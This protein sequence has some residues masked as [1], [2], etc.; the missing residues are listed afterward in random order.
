MLCTKCGTESTTGRKF[1]AACG[2][3]LSSRCPKC[4]AE[5]A[6]S[7]A[8]CEDCGAAIAGNAASSSPQV[9]LTTPEIRVTLGQPDVSTTLDGERKTVTAV[10]ADIRGSTEL[11]EDLDPEEARAIIDPALKLMIEAVQR[12]DG[13][14]VQSTGDGI[15]ALFGA[16][17]AHEDH[18]QRALYAALRMQE[19]L[20]RY[21]ERI[22]RD[23]R[24]PLQARVG[25]NT[26]EVVVR[27]LQTGAA[28]TEYTPI[29]HTTNLA[30]RIQALAPIG[31]IAVSEATRKLCEGYFVL[32][33]LGPTQIKGLSEP[34]NVSEVTGLGALRTHFQVSAHRGLTKFVGREREM[35]ALKRALEQ[36][37]AGRGQIAAAI[38]EPGVGKSRLFFEFKAVS[39]SGC[40]VLE[41]FSVSHGKASAY[42]PVLDFLY[43]YF[44]IKS[45]DDERKRREKVNG[46]IVTLDR[47]LEDALPY[48]FALLGI[49]EGE[50]PLAQMDGQIKKRR[51][52]EAIK[53]IL[54][55][56]SLNQPLIVI[57]EDLHWIDEQTQEFLNLLADSIGTAKIL[58]LVNYRPEYSHQWGS[59][60]YYTQLRLDPLGNESADEML[61]ALLGDDAAL[62]PLKRVIIEKTEGTPFFMEE[63][64]QVL[65]DEGALVRNGVVKLT[66]P[67]GE[68]KIPPTVQ[69]ILASRID[70]LLPD[71]KDLL[72]TLAVIG[73][74]FTLLLIRTV[75]TKPDNELSRLLNDLQLGEFIYEQPTVGDAEYIFKHALTQEVA[76]NSVLMER[77]KQ[78][79]ERIGAAL[80]TLYASS[81]DDHL[82]ELAHHY[83]RGNNPAKAVD[84]LGRAAR[85]AASRSAFGEAL[86]HARAGIALIPSMPASA[87]HGKRE[88][89][90]LP[91]LVRAATA[92]DGYGSPQTEQGYRRMLELARESGDDADLSTALEGSRVDH[93]TS[94]RHREAVEMARQLM[95]VAE[96][97]KKPGALADA[98]HARGFTLF[99]T[100]RYADS[101]SDLDRAITL[102]PDGAGRISLNVA[103]PLVESLGYAALGTWTLGFPD[104]AVNRIESAVKRSRDLRQPLLLSFALFFQTWIRLWRGEVLAAQRSCE[105]LEMLA[106]ESGFAPWLALNRINQGGIASMNGEHEQ[107]IALIRSGIANWTPLALTYHSSILARSCMQ[108]GRY[109]EA[110]DAVGVGREHVAR[111]GELHAE[112]EIERMAG[113]TL[114]RMG[115]ANIDEAGQC[116][117][118]AVA[119]AKGQG[120]KS[121]ELRATTS[122][123]RLLDKQNR[124][125]DAR[126]IVAEIYAWFT[127]GFDTADLRDAKALLDKLNG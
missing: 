68:L 12:Y 23:G 110:M 35:E 11:M 55:R 15:F 83:H 90:L 103:D 79:H 73:R 37:K 30:S 61:T 89:D 119:I 20:K 65:F 24:L 109:E 98:H 53:R 72:Q 7:S 26:G 70:R 9:A 32:R 66:K 29:G 56:E 85:Q 27:T 101:L 51:T 50:D 104:R 113:E 74:E 41:T 125:D 5:N 3:R 42:L 8:F 64:V 107:G 82:A 91:T 97:R 84:Y 94:G 57:F 22:R 77:R 62:A 54:L 39:Q 58:L 127:E 6:P 10:F 112:S 38:A 114:L 87:V 18:P 67:L 14:V 63:T 25:A 4:G 2:S 116:L 96:R 71:A 86:A 48:L 52:L 76:Y 95:V 16:P 60:T 47:A 17:T 40:A 43:G 123:A 28:H 121:F 102:C 19:G 100:G 45:E 1:C 31:S 46:K 44:E 93:G 81:L 88:F 92:I 33:S 105:E 13:Y 124:H 117:R 126:T 75:A 21:S 115:T 34:V 49:V 80:E 106:K 111:T 99:W 108:A 36:T 122:L 69:G 120:A 59:K 78:L 118:R